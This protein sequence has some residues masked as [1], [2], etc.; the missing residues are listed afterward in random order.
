MKNAHVRQGTPQQGKKAVIFFFF[1][2]FCHTQSDSHIWEAQISK[3]ISQKA[4]NK[5]GGVT[6][7]HTK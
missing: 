6:K 1:V 2:T 7:C 4:Y 3:L 5:G